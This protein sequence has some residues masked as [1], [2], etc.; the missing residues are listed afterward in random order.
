MTRDELL[1]RLNS[2]EWNDIEFKEAAWAIPKDALSTVSAFANTAGG[3]LVFGVKEENGTFSISGVINA[4]KVQNDFL[5]Q[6]R[7]HNKI[8]V[9]LPI[10]GELHTLDESTVIVF[11]VP[12]AQRNE[13]PVFLDGNPKKAHIRRGGRDDTC[14]GDELLRFIRDAAMDRF[15]AEPL[16]LDIRRCFD[17]SSVRWYR[18]RFASSNPGKGGTDD[19]AEFLRKWGFLIERGGVL[20]PTRAAVL[21]LGSDEYVRQVLPRMVVDLQFYRHKADEYSPSVRWSDR[22]T[23]E[24]NL[25]KA[26]Q[27]VVDFYFKHAE[28]PFS[29]D[30]ITLRRDDDP[31]DYISFREAAI[32][33]L[34]HQD[35]GDHTRVPVI[36]FFRDRVGM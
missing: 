5:G 25:I 30:A 18:A 29:V 21:V 35:F 16:D 17:E 13:K 10:T 8:S 33:L 24:V 11:Y 26:W 2:I 7:D 14:T 20:R 15:D 6:V 27:S 4:D 3:Y 28:R 1:A 34:I 32:N 23:V 22:D 19:D 12:E 36:R 9:Y 31:P